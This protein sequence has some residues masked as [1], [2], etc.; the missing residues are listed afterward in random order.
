MQN[1]EISTN[2][3]IIGILSIIVVIC[4]VILLQKK[5][6]VDDN[7]KEL[8][9]LKERQVAVIENN[10]IVKSKIEKQYKQLGNAE[11]KD[12]SKEF[13]DLF[14]NWNSW[15]KYTKNMLL[16]Q[17][18][19]PQIAKDSPVDVS[20]TMVGNGDSPLSGYSIEYYSTNQK[21]KLVEMITQTRNTPNTVTTTVWRGISRVDS[22]Q[23][24]YLDSLGSYMKTQ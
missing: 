3:K 23:L 9:E 8:E 20:G 14:Y 10:Q 7:L 1:H 21:G 6:A 12:Q 11:V 5:V 16:I 15:E 24:L 13:F 22:K 4:A 2:K 19:F 18:E 17:K